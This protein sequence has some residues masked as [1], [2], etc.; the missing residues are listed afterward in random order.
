[1]PP[2]TAR[3]GLPHPLQR[4]QERHDPTATHQDIQT[5]EQRIQDGRSLLT[6]REANGAEIHLVDYPKLEKR[7]YV[8]WLPSVQRLATILT[9]KG[10]FKKQRRWG[11]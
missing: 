5:L 4:L 7:T 11:T 9:D 10:V 1:M 2:L 3:K 6:Q 8:V